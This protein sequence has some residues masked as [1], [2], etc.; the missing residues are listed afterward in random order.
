MKTLHTLIAIVFA[1]PL[2]MH[3]Q[4]WSTSG[5][6]GLTTAN[7]L[8]TT[9]NKALIFK[10][11]NRENGR[12]LNTGAWRLGTATNFAKIDTTGKLTFGGTGVYVV[13]DNKFIFQYSGM[14]IKDCF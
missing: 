8:G 4:S 7:F 6:A 10:T 11:N 3:A 1:L 14:P 9:D 12:L 5:N 2:S 13:G